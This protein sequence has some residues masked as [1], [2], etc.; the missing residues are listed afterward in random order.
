MT[1]NTDPTSPQVL[2][3]YTLLQIAAEA[4]LGIDPE[5]TAAAPGA[6]AVPRSLIGN[7]SWLTEGNLHSSRM[8]DQ[9]A[10]EFANDWKVVSH[11][12][13]TAT[14]FSATLFEYIGSDPSKRLTSSKY[15]VSFRSTEFIED[16]ARDN[17]ATNQLEIS[18][19]G[20]AYGQ[21]ADMQAWWASVQPQIGASKVD[22]TGYSLGG[23]LATAF[24][25]LNK[26]QIGQVYTFN[27]AGVG[28]VK[29]GYN[30][31]QVIQVFGTQR[32]PGQ[33]A[34]S[35]TTAPAQARY[36]ELTQKYR[37]GQS[38]TDAAIQ[39]DRAALATQLNQ[40]KLSTSS[41]GQPYGQDIRE[42]ER[43]DLA[44]ERMSSVLRETVR[45]ATLADSKGLVPANINGSANVAGIQLDYQLA[46]LTAMDKTEF[47]GL[48]GAIGGIDVLLNTRREGATGLANFHDVYGA[49]FPSAVANSQRHYGSATPVFIE[50]QPLWRG[51]VVGDVLKVSWREGEVRLLVTQYDL[52]DFGD[53]HSIVLMA[54]SLRLQSLFTK[55]APATSQ[56]NL[57]S[58]LEA[59]SNSKANGVAG[60]QGTAEGD[61]L[62]RLLDATRLVFQ[63]P[64]SL[65]TPTASTLDGNTWHRMDLRQ[66]FENN[67]RGL[68]QMV[69]GLAGLVTVKLSGQDMKASI[70]FSAMVSLYALSPVVFSPSD[71]GATALDGLLSTSWG[72][73]RAAWEED[74]QRAASTPAELFNFTST[75][76]KARGQMLSAVVQRNQDNQRDN[77]PNA[78]APSAGGAIHFHDYA[79]GRT[80]DEGLA[81]QHGE[82]RHVVFAD[83]LG[84]S[85]TGQ[86]LSDSLFGGAGADGLDGAAGADWLEGGAGNDTLLGG[87]GNGKD[88]L[89]GGSGDDRLD[90][91]SGS[92]RLIG[93]VGNDAYVFAGTDIGND[94]VIDSDGLG[95]L[96]VG[97]LGQLTGGRRTEVGA[98]SFLSADRKVQYTLGSRGADGLRNVYIS[99]K[100]EAGVRGSIVVQGWREDRNLGLVFETSSSPV[101]IDRV[102]EGDRAKLVGA[103]GNYLLDET[104]GL[105]SAYVPGDGAGYQLG[106]PQPGAADVLN[107][108]S[109]T[110]DSI[111]GGGGNDALAGHGGGDYI[112]GGEGSDLIFGG[113]GADTLIGADGDDVIDGSRSVVLSTPSDN[114]TPQ[115]PNGYVL[116]YQG[117]GWIRYVTADYPGPQSGWVGFRNV[118][119][120]DEATNEANSDPVLNALGLGNFID[121]GAGGDL[122]WSGGGQDTVLGG[123]GGDGINGQWDDDLILGGEGNDN[124]WGDL[125]LDAHGS[126]YALHGDDLLDG[127]NGNDT[128]RGH[129]G[130]DTL[131][132]GDGDD[133]LRGDFKN[134]EDSDPLDTEGVFAN[135]DPLLLRGEDLLDGGA[136]N[137]RLVG[138]ADSDTLY[139]GDGQDSLWG[140]G[141]D[142]RAELQGR[143]YLDGGAGDDYLQGR[144]LEDTLLGGAGNDVLIGDSPVEELVLSLHGNDSLD[145]GLG[146]DTLVGMGGSDTLLGGD[147]DD[148]FFG[149]FRTGEGSDL[150][151]GADWIEGG[152]GSDS[153]RAGGG[154]DT[155]K[156]GADS[157]YLEGEAGEDVIDGGGATD[158]LT[159]GAGSDTLW[160]G[161]G[162][163][164]LQGGAGNDTYLFGTGD[165]LVDAQNQADF[166]EDTEGTNRL[167]LAAEAAGMQSQQL[168]DGSLLLNMA[169]SERLLISGPSLSHIASIHAGGETLSL[170]ELVGRTA[171]QPVHFE[172]SAA[173]QAVLSQSVALAS[174]AGAPLVASSSAPLS[175]TSS[176]EVWLGGYGNDTLFAGGADAVLSGGRGSDVMQSNY[177]GATYHYGLGD[178][179]DI[180]VAN[181]RNYADD[182]PKS[183]LV[184]GEGILPTDLVLSP[185][186]SSLD[187]DIFN[188][189]QAGRVTLNNFTAS[190]AQ[191][192]GG[193]SE[194][195]FSNGAVLTHAQ[196]VARGFDLVGTQA[197][198]YLSGTNLVD[199]FDGGA[200]DD[201]MLGGLGADAY[202]WGLG[203]GKDVIQ[204]AA[205]VVGEDDVIL[206]QDGLR[207]QE[208]QLNRMGN[209]LL[210]SV[211]SRPDR[212]R[213]TG[214]F[215]GT[216]VEALH[217]EDGTVWTAAELLARAL[218]GMGE[219]EAADELIGTAAA[220][221]IDGL[222][223]NDTI[224][225]MDG[226]DSL[227]GGLGNDELDGGSGNDSLFGGDGNDLLSGLTG[228]DLLEGQ[229]GNDTLIA[230]YS[231]SDTLYGGAGDDVLYVQGDAHVIRFGRGDGHDTVHGDAN[232]TTAIE[233]A[234]DVL[235]SDVRVHRAGSDYAAA[236]NLRLSIAGSAASITLNAFFEPA[237]D[238]NPYAGLRQVRFSNGTSWNLD[239][240]LRQMLLGSAGDD[241][242][243]GTKAAEQLEG[244]AGNDTLKGGAGNDTFRGGT[245]NDSMEG[246]AGDDLYLFSLGD[247]SDVISDL[248]GRSTIRF[249]AGINPADL[250]GRRTEET[251]D[252]VLMVGSGG[253]QLRVQGHFPTLYSS[254]NPIQRFEFADGSSWDSARIGDLVISITTP[255]GGAAMTGTES[256]ETWFGTS[257]SD[258][259]D[260]AGGNDWIHG[261][262]GDDNLAGGS[263]DD[264]L[265][266]GSG[267]DALNGGAGRDTLDGGAGI[268]VLNLSEGGD[269]LRFGRG[270]G[271]DDVSGFYA[272]G[273]WQGVIEFKPGVAPADVQVRNQGGYLSLVLPGG[274][275][276]LRLNQLFLNWGGPNMGPFANPEAP[277][278]R[279]A[280]GTIWTG[281]QL[282]AR[283]LSSSPE[284]DNLVGTAYGDT[285]A[286]GDGA[287]RLSGDYGA[288]LLMGDAGDDTLL[289]GSEDDTLQG[290]VGADYLSGS[291]GNDVLDGGIG[292]D[293]I[294]MGRGNNRILFGR[295]DGDDEV[296]NTYLDGVQNE[297]HFKPGITPADV[298]AR[299]DGSDLVLELK[300][301]QGSVRLKGFNVN[302]PL[303]NQIA[304]ADGT[305]WVPGGDGSQMMPGLTNAADVWVGTSGNDTINGLGGNDQ[306]DGQAGS[307]VLDGGSGADTLTGGAGDDQFHVDDTLDLVVEAPSGGF[308]TVVST[309][310]LTL[311]ANVERGVLPN[312]FDGQLIGNALNNL[313]EG[314]SRLDGGAGADTMSGGAGAD[315]YLVD[316]VDDVI[317]E[318][319]DGGYDFVTSSASYSLPAHVEDLVLSGSAPISGIGNAGPNV[320]TGNAGANRLVGG[321]GT[322]TLKGGAGNDTYVLDD[323]GDQIVEA[324]GAGTDSVEVGFDYTLPANLEN[325]LLTGTANLKGM[326][327]AVANLLVGNAGNNLLDGAAGDD[328][329]DGGQGVD[330][331]RGGAGN[332]VY[333]VDQAGDV[334]TEAASGGTDTVEASASYTL[335]V[336][337][338]KL[339]LTGTAHLN[340]T[341]NAAANTLT[342]NS[343][344]NRLDGGAGSDTMLGGAGDDT[345]VV[346]AAGDVVTEL[347]GNGSDTVETA[348][349]YTLPAE[350]ENLKLTGSG[351][352]TATG[353]A[354]SNVLTGNGANNRLDG[355]AGADTMAGGAGDDSY[356][357]DAAGDVITEVA[358]A[359]TDTVEAAVSYTLPA[360]VEKLTLTGTGNIDATGNAGANTLTGNSGAN[361]LDGGAG[362]DTLVGGTGNDT[363]VVDAAGDVVTEAASGGTDTVEASISYTLPAEVEKLTLTGTGANDAIGNSLANTLT[364]NGGNN[365]LDGKAGADAMA[366]GM[367]DD[368]YVLD[369]ASDV[370]T[371]ASGAGNDAVEASLNFTLPANVEEL[372]F[373]G[374]TGRTGVGNALA[375]RLTGTSGTDSLSG[376]DGNDTLDGGAGKDTLVGGK[377]DDTYVV[378]QADDVI[379]EL[380]GEGTD[381]VQSQV[382]L[383]LGTNLE[384]LTLLGTSAINATGNT[385]NNVLTGNTA[386]NTLSGGDGSDT[387]DGGAGNDSLVGGAGAD[388]YRFGRGYGSDTITENDAT[389]N[390]KDVVEFGTGVA[391]A[392][393]SFKRNGNALEVRLA[394]SPSELLTIKDW[395]LGSQYKVEEFRFVDSPGTVITDAQ[396][397]G[398]VQAMAAFGAQALEAGDG[399]LSRRRQHGQFGFGLAVGIEAAV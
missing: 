181:W 125:W 330:T 122:I 296:E 335:P 136:G 230:A 367:G 90:G 272:L 275:D 7:E 180:I 248:S 249:G 61:S 179:D 127:G 148:A 392:D 227:L 157:D 381:T 175:T 229:A 332:D 228:S 320:L 234:A 385:G 9:Q 88:T 22:V 321:G 156:G 360:E 216:G 352:V 383:T 391:P 14:G 160:G 163:D 71:N 342:G 86:G 6:G 259:L 15:V 295:G 370:I 307:D 190:A 203:D 32:E 355:K 141:E 155:I 91:G 322:D 5:A 366:G 210:I 145:G 288:D 187:I 82:M 207:P 223:G 183:R 112:N 280:D 42:L 266:G 199:R 92:D 166:V 130:S 369:N 298:L 103:L 24:Y 377:G 368:T 188:P 306:L 340:G 57:N 65:A 240:L 35:F 87:E 94:V 289:G 99:F 389:A 23:H 263:G 344:N 1:T 28:K 349:T 149:D 292:N 318:L 102:F 110:A 27:G 78:A 76:S 336:E 17:L 173:P 251:G 182:A 231:G 270:D 363:Y 215:A 208:V 329:L 312:A 302:Q 63:G 299:I 372:R 211:P 46:V 193:V 153:V 120:A 196:L 204:E 113:K 339:T 162:A 285:L 359:G 291:D 268:D 300:D 254:G 250:R 50:D 233:F 73:L 44:L 206:M 52:N 140:D 375:N 379:T 284:A 337:V 11:Q 397:A 314:G 4:F 16:A 301:G 74:Y 72:S 293:V 374:T 38:Y 80:F 39:A 390:I 338:E 174:E 327:N 237:G 129:G 45:V 276:E 152:A 239:D 212:L 138:D 34:S 380:A 54:D 105:D 305:R 170:A 62:E 81:D 287:D 93:G 345:Y 8:T 159:G 209:D 222:G 283:Y 217:F 309:I 197:A 325:L 358:G 242:V 40:L 56:S 265:L 331:L 29:D 214:H 21:I 317:V 133:D 144:G 12:P 55:L 26:P 286:G 106:N 84:R 58:F 19:G 151:D 198:N 387:L 69:S 67:I 178:G 201:T 139:G 95:T 192:H 364:G 334:V 135:L 281:A 388:R 226:A 274:V 304:F 244:Q 191:K 341:G 108:F 205:N 278:A 124:I 97:G 79:S 20:W 70:D 177:S 146:S 246:G 89:L 49:P 382:T 328:T 218:P 60:E 171:P 184:F 398:L 164:V 121:G 343:G 395:Y 51:T 43:L 394:G 346:D 316:N 131:I 386:V 13:N 47:A 310:D 243:Q 361:R 271:R 396:A 277:F 3:T 75:W 378:N 66:S 224:R 384:N 53:T 213:V 351:A 83:A 348:L 238:V 117:F 376:L 303:V 232:V 399:D 290:G 48:K 176:Q 393:V 10:Q 150:S 357:V 109:G 315:E 168:P 128:L 116:Q 256:A 255:W 262:G 142:A 104:R 25:E 194:F 30:L 37:A 189:L 167:V 111:V 186:G 235:P 294:N 273:A 269:A 313:L 68:E 350:V 220:D 319:S 165:S 137:D 114:T 373:T 221:T 161:A 297:L 365:R 185:S 64:A 333:R 119:L 158:V 347:T 77:Q 172:V 85:L 267:N 59:G 123:D 147:G 18:K 195:V 279:F 202:S 257:N 98:D 356:V 326:G 258:T 126:N 252:L 354:S 282:T 241:W 225:G 324:S 101:A 132:G 264:E 245:G 154:N 371:E 143:D 308:D 41:L 169:G 311:P 362:A 118:A 31:G 134:A 107:G 96:T 100:S 219:S 261:A 260:G 200:G 33:N 2:Q 36:A 115:V 323:A 253:D 353:N 236:Q 247:G